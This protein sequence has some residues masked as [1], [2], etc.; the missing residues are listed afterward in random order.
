VTEVTPSLL[1]F[2]IRQCGNQEL[3]E[4]LAQETWLRVW[5][6]RHAYVAGRSSVRGSIASPVNTH[7]NRLR[8]ESYRRAASLDAETVDGGGPL[9]ATLEDVAW[10]APS[11]RLEAAELAVRV[12]RAVDALPPTQR[13]AVLL[14][15]FEGLSYEDIA[16]TLD[17][18]LQAVKS[19]LNRAKTR[20]HVLLA[21]DATTTDPARSDH[22]DRR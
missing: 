17:L 20:L 4:D 9:S 22:G 11:A 2:L 19:L 3:A 6:S 13:A 12:R 21:D 10:P 14:F 18:S 5:R 15:R 7:L 8:S 1:R 16:T